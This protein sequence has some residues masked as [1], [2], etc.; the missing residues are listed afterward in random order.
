MPFPVPPLTPYLVVSD[1]RAALK[2][3]EEAF[4]GIR[5]GEPHV[6]PNTGKIMHARIVIHGGLIMLADDCGELMNRPPSTPQALGGSPIT[7]ALHVDDA[8]AFWDKAIAAG[9]TSTMPLADTFWGERYGQLTD[10]F[11][12]LWSVSQTLQHMTDEE[13]QASAEKA[14]TQKNNLTG[15]FA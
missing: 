15:D 11:G 4:S 12:H 6:M 14:M 1:A 2:F 3:Y 7:L 9:A 8:R 13:M 10:P 5:D